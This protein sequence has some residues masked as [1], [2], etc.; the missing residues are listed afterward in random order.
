[1]MKFS[2]N[3]EKLLPFVKLCAQVAMRAVTSPVLNNIHLQAEKGNKLNIYSTDKDVELSCVVEIELEEAGA[4]IL[5]ARKVLEICNAL[6]F[7]ET[8]EFSSTVIEGEHVM[9]IKAGRNRFSLTKIPM[10]EYPMRQDGKENFGHKYNL[11]AKDLR[12]LLNMTKFAM[13]R[14]DTRVFLNGL[15]FDFHNG[16][17]TCVGCDGHRIAVSRNRLILGETKGKGAK[18]DKTDKGE[19]EEGKGASEPAID[20]DATSDGLQIIIPHSVVDDLLKIL[21]SSDEIA[22]Q[23]G[24]DFAR[25]STPSISMKTNLLRGVY[26]QYKRLIPT[27]NEKVMRV[28]RNTIREALSR[29]KVVSDAQSRVAQLKIYSDRLQITAEG[30]EKNKAEIEI[31]VE[32]KGPEEEL[33][34]ALKIDYLLEVLQNSQAE[35]LLFHL[36]DSETGC[37]IEEDG[38]GDYHY[39][40]MPILV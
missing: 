1:M 5:S 18:K 8:I 16:A 39:V 9:K 7:D 23:V 30:S 10:E 29:A 35:H 13:A 15:L 38:N 27:S 2:V 19:P 11:V 25:F 4:A 37:L 20:A 12:H 40:V 3:R 32:F 24:E 36:K 21:D 17:L 26:P 6:P 31:D 34:L 14:E 28:V 33:T 22:L